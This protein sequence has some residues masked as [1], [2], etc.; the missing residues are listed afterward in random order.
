[1]EVH[2]SAEMSFREVV[3]AIGYNGAAK[4]SY[5]IESGFASKLY[6][7]ASQFACK[8]GARKWCNQILFS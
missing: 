3:P 5:T 4:R 8:K 7:G 1:M 2:L 6:Y